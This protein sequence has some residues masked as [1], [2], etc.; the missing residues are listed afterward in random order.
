MEQIAFSII[1]PCY[2]VE[3][4]VEHCVEALRRQTYQDMEIILIDD[5]STDATPALCRAL[6]AKYENVVFTTH[7]TEGGQAPGNRGLEATRNRGLEVARGR[8]VWFL[9]ADDTLEDNALQR[10]KEAFDREMAADFVL[11]GFTYV[12]EDGSPEKRMV[13]DLPA[14]LYSAQE[15]AANVFDKMSW[16]VMSCA[17]TKVYKKEFLDRHALRFDI[18][19]KFN[20]D[21]A[22]AIGAFRQ[23]Q[24]I[25]CLPVPLYRYLQRAGS[26]M[27]SR[28]ANAYGSLNRV[29][30]LLGEYFR[31]YDVLPQKEGYIA[32]RRWEIIRTLL[33]E[34]IDY[35]GYRAYAA[36]FR[37]LR[38]DRDAAD[39]CA[40]RALPGREPVF[41][42]V[43][44]ALFRHRMCLTMYLSFRVRDLVRGRR[45]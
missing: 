28:R 17:G 24:M 27:H 15:M 22:F 11:T 7:K 41:S 37:A 3:S 10:V 38:A 14:G 18:R 5:G 20:E 12:Y 29:L 8:W 30:G 45:S 34:E 2:N 40:R 43:Q 19:Y 35:K 36:L 16:P 32:A 26:I 25:F 33:R 23:A 21:G 9:D 31:A 6:A 4:Y 39:T 42:R 1:V 44:F 13:P